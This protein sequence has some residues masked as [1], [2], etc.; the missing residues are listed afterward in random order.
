MVI[1]AAGRAYNIPF[2]R[3]PKRW[4]LSL[5]LCNQ[6]WDPTWWCILVF[7]LK[8]G[9]FDF[10]KNILHYFSFFFFLRFHFPY[11]FA[12]IPLTTFMMFNQIWPTLFF[13]QCFLSLNLSL[14]TNR[15]TILWLKKKQSHMGPYIGQ[16]L[17]L[18]DHTPW[19][20]DFCFWDWVWDMVLLGIPGPPLHTSKNRYDTK[21]SMGWP[22]FGHPSFGM[23]KNRVFRDL[24]AWH[25]C[26]FVFS[27]YSWKGPKGGCQGDIYGCTVCIQNQYR[28]WQLRW[29]FSWEIP[30]KQYK[31]SHMTID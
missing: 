20:Y 12:F 28:S 26:T 29:P 15:P 11:D 1:P 23:T 31:L 5:F 24:L 4:N 27:R 25:F 19:D 7:G 8:V 30:T 6:P 2:V 13:S 3:D 17:T 18:C 9:Y 10:V 21:R 16:I 14:V 22:M